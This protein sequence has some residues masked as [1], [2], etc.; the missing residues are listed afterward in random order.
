MVTL[1]GP[2][3]DHPRAR[4]VPLSSIDMM[5]VPGGQEQQSVSGND[6]A[7]TL[8]CRYAPGHGANAF[9]FSCE[10][11]VTMHGTGVAMSATRIAMYETDLVFIRS[12][13]VAFRCDYSSS[14]DR[15]PKSI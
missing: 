14:L 13:G 11:P 7:P 1:A 10:R 8:S 3:G 12:I 2:V 4:S 9:A 6:R 5:G 15:I